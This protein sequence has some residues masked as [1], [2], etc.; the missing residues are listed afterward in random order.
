MTINYIHHFADLFVSFDP[1]ALFINYLGGGH[2]LT[3]ELTK[4][5]GGEGESVEQRVLVHRL[6]GNKRVKMYP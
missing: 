1:L 5:G 4:E 3:P 2:N 6:K